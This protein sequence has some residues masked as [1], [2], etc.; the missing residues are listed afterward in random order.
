LRRIERGIAKVEER[1]KNEEKDA[2]KSKEMCETQIE[3]GRHY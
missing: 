2:M 3:F 1:K